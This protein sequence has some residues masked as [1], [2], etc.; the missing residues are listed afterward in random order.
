MNK[1]VKLEHRELIVKKLPL[2]K[3][4]EL[5]KAFEKLPLEINNLSGLEN[6]DLIP[7][8]PAI[9]GNCY[10]DIQKLF[11]IATDLTVD[12][13]DKIGLAEAV[14]IFLA[15]YEVNDYRSIYEK[16]KKNF[17]AQIKVKATGTGG[18]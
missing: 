11:I 1:T 9:I 6:K 8:I 15:I 3:Y 5:L 17:T 16:I 4:A 18:L 7:R 14:D 2:A 10:P 12:E 13:V